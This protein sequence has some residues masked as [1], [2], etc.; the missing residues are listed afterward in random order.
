MIPLR[1][2]LESTPTLRSSRHSLSN[3][4]GVSLLSMLKKAEAHNKP[5]VEHEA[6]ATIARIYSHNSPSHFSEDCIV[7]PFLSREAGLSASASRRYPSLSS[8]TW[9]LPQELAVM[10]D[11]KKADN[12]AKSIA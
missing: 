3:F 12:T 5:A 10:D 1:T 6:K 11:K 7:L 4:S 8:R 2:S 9:G